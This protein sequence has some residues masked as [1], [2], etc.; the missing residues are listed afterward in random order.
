VIE[1]SDEFGELSGWGHYLM[2]VSRTGDAFD[3]GI[4]QGG[5]EVARIRALWST[6]QSAS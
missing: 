2:D 1:P 6:V 4:R 3:A 5:T